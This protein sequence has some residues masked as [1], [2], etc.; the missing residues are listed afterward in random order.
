MGEGSG[1]AAFIDAPRQPHSTRLASLV[2]LPAARFARRGREKSNKKSRA[3]GPPSIVL[4]R[5]LV[6]ARRLTE[7]DAIDRAGVVIGDQQ[8]PVLHHQEIDRPA[9]VVVVL[10]VTG[11]ERTK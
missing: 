8:R 2:I 10:E 7:A 4:R 9:D 6:A 3:A 1:V 11:E 5:R